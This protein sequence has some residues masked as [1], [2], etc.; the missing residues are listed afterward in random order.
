MKP[1]IHD[2]FLL[3]TDLAAELYHDH[4]EKLPI[5]DYHCHLPVAQIAQ[6]HRFRSITEIWLEG[7]HYK[8][9]AMRANGVPERFCTGDASDWEKFEAWARTV[10]FA[11]RNPLYHWTHME[12]KHP[13]GIAELLDARTARGIFDRC[14]ELLTQPGFSA[15]GLLQHFRV[16]VVCT[17]DDPI[18]SLAHHA[19]LAAQADRETRVYPTFRPDRVLA[20]GDPRA[21]NAW[22]DRLGEAAGLSVGTFASLLEAL[23]ARHAFFHAAGCRASDHG[24]EQIDAEPWTDGEASKVFT[25]LRRGET[26]ESGEARG[27]RSAL[28]HRLALLDHA[29]G[30]VQQ[31]HLGAL[32][33]NNT[34]L[35]LRLGADSGLDSIGD[36]PQARSLARFLDRLDS[37]EQLAKTILYNLNPADNEVFATMAGNFQD[38]TLPGKIQYGPAWWF[39]DQLDGMQAQMRAL[40]SMGLFSRFVGMVTDSR[41]FLSY[42]RHDYFRRLLCN[43]LGHDVR[44]G[45]VPHDSAMLGRLVEAISFFNAREYLGLELGTLGRGLEPAK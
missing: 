21:W 29:R 8:W 13:F 27:F 4:A 7:D 43:L 25:R 33:D 30:W 34:R 44:R 3:E 23:E 24:L 9:R 41:S 10:P 26:P 2:D 45:L 12:L 31:F 22:V 32:R 39:L 1:F 37:T 11:L 19:T 15:Q 20:T 42:P 18:D 5:I 38:G 6:D 28:L 35:R 17:T 36:F 40:S 14:N 16:A